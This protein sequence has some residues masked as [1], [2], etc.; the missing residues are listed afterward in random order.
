M[1]QWEKRWPFSPPNRTNAFNVFFFSGVTVEATVAASD[2]LIAPHYCIKC[3]KPRALNATRFLPF[4]VAARDS[5][6][7]NGMTWP[8]TVNRLIYFR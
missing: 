8:P 7:S 4:Y 2:A 6:K 3:T 5:L 1:D